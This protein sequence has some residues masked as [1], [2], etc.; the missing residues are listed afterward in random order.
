LL[1]FRSNHT[2]I[3]PQERI[4]AKQIMRLASA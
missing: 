4:K 2:H 1:S 3:L